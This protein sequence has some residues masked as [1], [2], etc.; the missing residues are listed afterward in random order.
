MSL[1]KQYL[2]TKPVVKVTFRL[3]ADVA[4]QA[5]SVSLVG[6]FN[7][8]SHSAS[9]MKQLKDGSFKKVL[10]LEAGKKFEYRYLID[11]KNWTN[12]GDADDYIESSYGNC[13]NSVVRT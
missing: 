4:S 9:P 10:D 12:D 13:E 8:W 5:K 6:E 7:D 3:S 11:Q 1:K 2:K